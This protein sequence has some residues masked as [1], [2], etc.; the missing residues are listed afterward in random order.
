MPIN[1]K[2]Q[3]PHISI[4]VMKLG[5]TILQ[6]TNTDHWQQKKAPS[7]PVFLHRNFFLLWSISFHNSPSSEVTLRF[8][9]VSSF[10]SV[11]ALFLSWHSQAITFSYLATKK[12]TTYKKKEVLDTAIENG[13]TGK[14]LR[15]K[16][17]NQQQHLFTV[18]IAHDGQLNKNRWFKATAHFLPANTSQ[19]NHLT[20][21]VRQNINS[22]EKVIFPSSNSCF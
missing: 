7:M 15:T 4:E 3:W 6:I 5:K 9:S 20:K 18:L 10:L 8:P 17:I 16:V 19:H 1:G 22:W 21:T 14:G 2:W 13:C 11:T 12:F